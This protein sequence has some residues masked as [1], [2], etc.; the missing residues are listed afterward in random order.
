[1]RG[2][3]VVLIVVTTDFLRSRYCLEELRWACD[4]VQ[5]TGQQAQQRLQHSGALA[6]VPIFYHDQDP[7]VGFGVDKLRQEVLHKIL[8]QRHAAAS[9][10][11]RTHWIDALLLLAKQ[12][13][14]R[15]DSTGRCEAG[16]ANA[17]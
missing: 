15:H 9:V 12:T 7:I 10:D 1:M 8:R 14:I 13:G 17:C 3:S 4:E 11:E 16:A 6:L 5:Q 2:A